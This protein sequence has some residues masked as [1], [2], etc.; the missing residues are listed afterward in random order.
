VQGARGTAIPGYALTDA[1]EVYGDSLNVAAAWK[2]RETDVGALAG[3]PVR[4][5]FVVRDADL[6]FCRFEHV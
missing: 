5:R 6:F 4:L 3:K 2:K 1:H